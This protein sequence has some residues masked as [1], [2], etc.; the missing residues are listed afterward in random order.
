[1]TTDSS[2]STWFHKTVRFS[3]SK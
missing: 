1:L 3:R 2:H